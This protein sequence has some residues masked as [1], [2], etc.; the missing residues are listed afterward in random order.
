MGLADRISK[1]C[2]SMD[3]LPFEDGE[4]DIIWSE[5]AIFV[6]GFEKELA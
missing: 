2:A 1:V 6:M 5:G 4:F 3:D